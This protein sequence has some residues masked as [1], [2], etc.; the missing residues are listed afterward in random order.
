MPDSIDGSGYHKESFTDVFDNLCDQVRSIFGQDIDVSEDSIDGQYLAIFAAARDSFSELLQTIYNARSPQGAVGDDLSR[1][2]ALNGVTR[3]KAT[4]SRV[5]LEVDGTL[6]TLV[7]QG[8]N[9]QSTVDESIIFVTDEDV[10]LGSSLTLIPATC[11]AIGSIGAAPNTLTK[12]VNPVYGLGSVTNPNS[13]IVGEP[14]ETDAELR[15]RRLA[16]V[17]LPSQ[18]L[19][20]GILAEILQTKDVS[21]AKVYQNVTDEV[22]NSI[23]PHSI[24]AIVKGGENKDV[25]QSIYKHDTGFGMKGDITVTLQDSQGDN[26]DIL[27]SRPRDVA[28]YIT[29]YIQILDGFPSDG[30]QKIKDNLIQYGNTLKIGQ[31][32]IQSILYTVVNT[33]TNLSIQSILIGLSTNPTDT[34]DISM[35]IDQLPSILQDNIIIQHV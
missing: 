12:I 1:L 34:K 15:Q 11:T 16:S 7:P 2:C 10:R 19:V 28:I 25:A 30:D 32:I 27:F 23:P 31:K 33:V 14:E 6:G 26:K 20:D 8:T 4:Y 18:G 5:S 24:Y 3:K 21:Q 17:T 22:V 9:I 35:E 13:A 29:I